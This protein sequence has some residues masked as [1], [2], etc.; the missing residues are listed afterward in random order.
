VGLK[1]ICGGDF[2]RKSRSASKI[3]AMISVKQALEIH[4][5]AVQEFGGSLGLR[6]S[7]GLESAL[8]RPFQAFG[9]IYILI[10][11]RRLLQLEKE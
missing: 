1:K 7:G 2:G 5:I 4:E 9:G 11:F 3:G 6:D 8:A 10:S